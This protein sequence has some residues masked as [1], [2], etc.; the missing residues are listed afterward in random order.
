VV[1]SLT[2]HE[3]K[4]RFGKQI[5]HLV[6]I[7]TH[8]RS[9][10]HCM[11]IEAAPLRTGWPVGAFH[12]LPGTRRT[13]RRGRGLPRELCRCAAAVVAVRKD[14]LQSSEAGAAEP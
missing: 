3:G 13:R 11:P 6:W 7:S 1:I 9:R 2:D 4:P 10:A 14:L 8:S 5:A 12:S